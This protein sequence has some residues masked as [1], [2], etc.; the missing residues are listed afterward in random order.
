MMRVCNK[1][2]RSESETEFPNSN[3]LYKSCKEC[4]RKIN[5]DWQRNK[6]TTDPE[7][8]KKGNFYTRQYQQRMMSENPVE[9]KAHLS[10]IRANTRQR[11]KEKRQNDPEYDERVRLIT[12]VRTRIC[13]FLKGEKCGQKTVQLMGFQTKDDVMRYFNDVYGGMSSFVNPSHDH[14]IPIKL[15][16]L[17]NSRHVEAFSH[18]LNLRLIENQENRKKSCSFIGFPTVEY[19]GKKW[20]DLFP[21]VA[22]DILETLM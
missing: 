5:N 15:F 17:S 19:N 11:C 13:K 16:N 7:W 20:E 2:N 6:R 4:R 12:N 18:H 9:Y 1:C 8:R 10:Q 22:K 14:Y 21:D 3:R